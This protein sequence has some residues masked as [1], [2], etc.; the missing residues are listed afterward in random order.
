MLFGFNK[1]SWTRYVENEGQWADDDKSVLKW[2]AEYDQWTAFF[3]I[4]DNFHNQ[5]PNR[6]FRMEGIDVTQLTVHSY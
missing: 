2:V 6:N 4:L 1:A 5:T 3:Y